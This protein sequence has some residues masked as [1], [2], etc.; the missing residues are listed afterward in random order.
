MAKLENKNNHLTKENILLKARLASCEE[1]LATQNIV[2]N[3]SRKDKSVQTTILLK[4][5]PSPVTEQTGDMC[6]A[7]APGGPAADVRAASRGGA[8]HRLSASSPLPEAAGLGGGVSLPQPA[9][10]PAA[11]GGFLAELSLLVLWLPPAVNSPTPE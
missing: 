9:R 2:R 4:R 10:S 7:S 6:S 1:A 3:S 8:G 5:V 11:A